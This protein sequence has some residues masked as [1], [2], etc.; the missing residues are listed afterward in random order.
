MSSTNFTWF[1]LEYI[2]QFLTRLTA[3]TNSNKQSRQNLLEIQLLLIFEKKTG[4][5]PRS[6]HLSSAERQKIIRISAIQEQL[7]LQS[8]FFLNHRK[9]SSFSETIHFHTNKVNSKNINT[10][11]QKFKTGQIS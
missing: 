7:L 1:I 4:V 6:I 3:T 8:K 9:S 2:D 5:F 11:V 10:A